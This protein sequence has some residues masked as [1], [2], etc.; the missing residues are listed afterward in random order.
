VLPHNTEDQNLS[1]TYR[2]SAVYG[3]LS[4]S[5]RA[6]RSGG[7]K[8]ILIIE[9]DRDIVELVRY[10]LAN[11]GFQVMAA[12]DGGSGL[13]SL[14]KSPP[15]LLLLDLM[16]PKLSGLDICREVRKDESLNRLP[17]LML[18]ARGDEAD[19]VVGLEMGADDYVTKPFSPRELLARVKALLRRAE[20]PVDA[21]RTIEVGKLAIDPA[22]YRV[23]YAGKPVPLSTLEFRLLYY[24]ASRPNRVF[25][26]DQLLDAVWGTDRFV[27][28]RSVD[29]Y[30]RRLRE[31]IETDPENPLHVK[32]VRGAGYLFETRA[33]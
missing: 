16:L 1:Y 21:P 31:K 33:A 15:D 24:L 2:K 23:S 25:T 3:T 26:R 30:V 22:S 4:P 20:P 18:T 14:K 6:V 27:T 29:V 10:N 9:D 32:T 12:F 19:R 13:T 7:M 17:I 8:R 11:E 5:R 28:P